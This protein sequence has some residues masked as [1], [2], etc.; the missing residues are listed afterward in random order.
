M[1]TFRSNTIL[2]RGVSV[3]DVD[4]SDADF[5]LTD[6]SDSDLSDADSSWGTSSFS[7]MLMIS[8]DF[9]VSFE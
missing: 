2:W 6:F 4:G 5:P 9:G 3:P 7:S 1:E 8:G